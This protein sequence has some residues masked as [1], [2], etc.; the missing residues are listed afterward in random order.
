MRIV[1]LSGTVLP[2][3]SDE[4]IHFPLEGVVGPGHNAEDLVLRIASFLLFVYFRKIICYLN[5]F[6]T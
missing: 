2:S 4:I 3:Y 6:V 5:F 1:P